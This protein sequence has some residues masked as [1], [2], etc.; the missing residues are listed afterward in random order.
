VANHPDATHYR[1]A[2]VMRHSGLLAVDGFNPFGSSN[3][4]VRL[5]PAADVSSEDVVAKLRQEIKLRVSRR[6]SAHRL[7]RSNPARP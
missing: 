3:D 6:G 4:T 1:V 5:T 2:N 7:T